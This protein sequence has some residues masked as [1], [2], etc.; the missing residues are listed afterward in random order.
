MRSLELFY[1]FGAIF[2]LIIVLIALPTLI[3]E[4]KRKKR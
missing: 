2:M 1:L 4:A 3:D